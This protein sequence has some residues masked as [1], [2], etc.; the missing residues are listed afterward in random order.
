MYNLAI[1][2]KV[3]EGK[4][5]DSI[6]LKSGKNFISL[7]VDDIILFVKTASQQEIVV[8]GVLDEFSQAWGLLS[9]WSL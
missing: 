8:K 7:F 6:W 1:Q 5:R 2:E 3:D 4:W 9:C